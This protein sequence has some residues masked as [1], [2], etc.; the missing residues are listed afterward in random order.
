[1][2]DIYSSKQ[3][4]ERIKNNDKKIAEKLDYSEIE[5]PVNKKN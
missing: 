4:P 5:F 3:H 2:L 1:M